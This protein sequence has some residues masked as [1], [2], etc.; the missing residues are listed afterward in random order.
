MIPALQDT[1]GIP[2]LVFWIWGITLAIAI[3]V[4]LPL[5]VYL[6]NR[7][8][9]AAKNIER[10]LAEMRDAGL[11]IAKN[12]SNIKALDDTIGVATQ[13]LETADSIKGHA[14]TIEMTLASRSN[15]NVRK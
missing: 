4:I 2:D 13:I 6:L 8:W 9:I 11:G 1:S 15:G 7:T 10:Y 3:V 5:V 14:A 12:T